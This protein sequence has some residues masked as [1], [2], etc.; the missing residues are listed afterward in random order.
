MAGCLTSSSNAKVTTPS[1]YS[2]KKR[3][4]HFW[5]GGSEEEQKS[6]QFHHL[7]HYGVKVLTRDLC[8]ALSKSVPSGAKHSQPAYSALAWPKREQ[9]PVN[10]KATDTQTYIHTHACGPA[11]TLLECG[12]RPRLKPRTAPTTWLWGISVNHLFNV[13]LGRILRHAIKNVV[14][15]N[16][17]LILW[18]VRKNLWTIDLH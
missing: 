15:L 12:R 9:L 10:A 14:S 2:T 4:C 13:L 16:E 5:W 1:S 8:V 18:P 3:R 7:H 17:L 11:K 6:E